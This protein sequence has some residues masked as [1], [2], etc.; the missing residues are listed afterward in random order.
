MAQPSTR[1]REIEA[2]RNSKAY[3]AAKAQLQSRQWRLDNLYWIKDKDANEIPYRRNVSQ[4]AFGKG[5][6]FRNVIVKARQLGF[7]TDIAMQ[8]TDDLIFRPNTKAA[9]IDYTLPDAEKKLDKI[10]F[11]IERLPEAIRAGVRTIKNNDAEMTFTNGSEVTVGTSFR[12]DTPQVLHVSEYG[13]IALENPKAAKEIKTGA[14]Q[15]VGMNGKIDIESTAHGVG[16]EFHDLVQRAEA[17]QK[18]ATPLTRLD[19]KLHFF[20]WHL[21]P[22]YRLQ[23][24]LVTVTKETRDYFDEMRTKYGLIVDPAQVAWYANK[25]KELGPDDMWQEYPS[26]MEE[27]F[28]NSLE[29]AYFKQQMATARVEKR[30]GQPVPYDPTRPV[31][32]FSDIGVRDDQCIWFHQSDGVRHRLIDYDDSSAGISGYIRVLKEKQAARGFIYGTHY[33]PHD[34]EVQDWSHPE[35]KTRKETAKGFGLELS[36]VQAPKVKME[37]IDATRRFLATCYID[38]IHCERGIKCLD[39]YRKEWDERLGTWS[40]DPLHNWAS[41][42]ADALQTGALGYKHPNAGKASPNAIIGERKGSA[43]S[44]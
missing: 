40:K 4:Q 25:L 37:G 24:N 26:V 43:W 41:H 38:S 2:A 8:M 32:T 12:G 44:S 14:I 13:K 9:I 34:I 36:T 23:P 15:A 22:Q 27:A 7:S 39:N 16:G 35:A 18:E 28:F 29:G 11:A 42:G 3:K 10:R 30:I 20:G 17:K 33:A 1:P 6:W 19:F 21:D 5:L 31:N